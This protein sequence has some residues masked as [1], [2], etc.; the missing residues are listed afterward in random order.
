VHIPVFFNLQVFTNSVPG[1]NPD[2]G[3]R[4]TS[5]TNSTWSQE[6]SGVGVEVGVRVGKKVGVEVG[7]AAWAVRIRP[8]V[9]TSAA[10]VES[11]I[12]VFSKLTRVAWILSAVIVGR[13]ATAW[14]WQLVIANPR[15]KRIGERL[16]DFNLNFPL[17][18]LLFIIK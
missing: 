6:N 3:G 9:S 17:I 2:P 14:N 12:L 4:L 11:E 7:M 8:C 10:R 16:D 13:G 15:K 5:R 1:G 18:R